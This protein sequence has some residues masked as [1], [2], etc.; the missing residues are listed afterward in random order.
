VIEGKAALEGA[1]AGLS[2]LE[3]VVQFVRKA[4]EEGKRVAIADILQRMP[5]DAFGIAGELVT[6]IEQLKQEFLSNKIDLKKTIDQ[7]QAETYWWKSKK[8]RLVRSFEAKINSLVTASSHLV[9]DFVAVANCREA[10]ELVAS[11][12]GDGMK[13]QSALSGIVDAN[14]PVGDIFDDL[15]KYARRI[16]ADL[17]DLSQGKAP[18]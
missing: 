6:A 12:F 1:K 2:L 8:Y 14:R 13:I 11:S 4:R 18:A 7:L 16:R 3:N 5:S 17:G 10:D 15:L 9:E